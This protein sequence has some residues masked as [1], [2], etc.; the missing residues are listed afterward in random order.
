MLLQLLTT[1]ALLE[2]M[3]P[4]ARE[5]KGLKSLM[6][7]PGTGPQQ[8]TSVQDPQFGTLLVGSTGLLAALFHGRD[9]P[10]PGW[11]GS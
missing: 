10:L 8:G 4:A 9:P 6:E 2:G 7:E 11:A 3:V 1:A 5:R